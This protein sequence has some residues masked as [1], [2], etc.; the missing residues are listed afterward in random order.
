MNQLK[1]DKLFPEQLLNSLIFSV[2]VTDLGGRFKYV[3]PLFQYKFSHLSTDFSQLN[4]AQTVYA[5]D[6]K[7]CNDAAKECIKHPEKHVT[8][9]VRKA[10]EGEDYFWTTWEISV[11]KNDD[12]QIEG[13]ISIGHDVTNTQS[14]INKTSDLTDNV[15]TILNQQLQKF[16]D[17]I[18]GVLYRFIADENYTIQFFS[19]GIESLTGYTSAELSVNRKA[20]Y[21]HL[22][23]KDDLPMVDAAI[24]VAID[25]K[26]KYE[27]E[28][29]IIHKD[30]EIRWVF[31]RGGAVYDAEENITYLDGSIFDVTSRKKVEAALERSE[32]EVKR[33]ALVA[34][35]TTNSVL[36]ADINQH[37]IWV[38]EGFTRI[39]GYTL[40]E[41]R[42]KKIGYSL[43]GP[44]VDEK[45][46][47][48]LQYSLDNKLAFKE[49]FLSYTKSG[50]PL[51]LEVDCQPL[52]DENNV[53]IGFMSIETDI[54]RRQQAQLDQEELLQR[55][56]L[57]TD[58][59]QIAIW[60]IDLATNH[61]IWDDKMFEMYGYEKDPAFPPYKIW[62]RAVHPDDLEMMQKVIGQLIDGK[63]EIDSAVYRITTPNGRVRHIES[64]A[65][66]KKSPS[67][68]ILRLIGTNRNIT[69]DILV[70]EKLKTQNKVLRDIA[71]IQSHEVRRPLANILGVIEVLNSSNSVNN[72]EIFDHLIES[73]NELDM[74][75]RSIVKKTNNLDG[76][77]AS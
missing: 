46:K 58:S 39:S 30:K 76:L 27:L 25:N 16:V 44:K 56:T 34:H 66:V 24:E 32:D 29:R 71:F 75:I 54:T 64:H 12:G 8:V 5:D 51:W 11:L 45:A 3:N 19:E 35:N 72:K 26:H 10:S 21:N 31:E 33:L 4:F 68:K 63:R 38:N 2:V 47:K 28:Y 43:D 53:H 73:A 67:G 50:N 22:I 62:K 14:V 7:L 6:V 60:E 20:G 41:I 23:F 70:Q 57:A 52:F 69:D 1:A 13:I 74:Q 40:E 48:R 17:H 36:I 65:I 15:K 49:E 59:A 42:G 77:M 18:P 37:I 61:I 55:L 9:T